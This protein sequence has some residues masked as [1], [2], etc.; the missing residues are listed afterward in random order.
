MAR[1]KYVLEHR[2]VMSDYLGRPLLGRET[3]HHKNGN[4]SDNRIDNLELWSSAQPAGQSVE[5]KVQFALEI[6]ATYRPEA[7]ASST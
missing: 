2:M 1:G 4:R 6:L 3:V 7:L 5:D